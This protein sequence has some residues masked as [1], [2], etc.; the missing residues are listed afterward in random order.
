MVRDG[1][2]VSVYLNGKTEPEISGQARSALPPGLDQV[3]IGGGNV[4]L[5]DFYGKICEV[6]IYD[7][8]LTPQ[9][10]AE[11]YSAGVGRQ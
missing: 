3:F 5:T 6:S 2:N 8:A 1:G 11:H 9:E 4:N 10:I 7:K